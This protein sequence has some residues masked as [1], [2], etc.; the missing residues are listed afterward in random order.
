MLFISQNSLQII[1]ILIIICAKS[2][3]TKYGNIMKIITARDLK[4]RLDHDEILLV[5]VREPIEHKAEFIKGAHLSPL[6]EVS[7]DKLL[8]KSL[9]IV[10]H[11]HSGKRSAAAC[12]K[13]LS[14]DPT[15]EIYSLEGGIA[16]WK[17]AGFDVKKSSSSSISID[18]Q[19]QIFAGFLTFAGVML[20]T[21]LDSRFYFLSGFVGLGLML[22]GITGWCGTAKLLAKMPWNR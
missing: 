19:T 8:S 20:G 5:D 6:G 3:L 2:L 17:E 16:A 14:Q 9:P 15:L 13:L 1:E 10:M 11:C 18:R 4:K 12:Q 21:F 7:I 22:A